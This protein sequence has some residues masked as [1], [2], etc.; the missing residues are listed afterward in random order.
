MSDEFSA[1][2]SDLLDGTYDCV[3]RM[4]LNAYN[5]LCASPGGF[6]T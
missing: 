1:P 6:R 4:V 5:P 2:Y 3:D